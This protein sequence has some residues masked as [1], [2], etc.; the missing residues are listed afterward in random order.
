ML[1]Y[2]YRIATEYQRHHGVA[3]TL[4]YLSPDHLAQLR[5]ELSGIDGLEGI[6]RFLG[7]E[8]LIDREIRHPHVAWSRIHWC[9]HEQGSHG[10]HAPAPHRAGARRDTM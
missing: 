1:S 2:L 3:P 6:S 8:M 10:D 5:T 7:M 4:L 9:R